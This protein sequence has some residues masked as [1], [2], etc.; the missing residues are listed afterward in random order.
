MNQNLP[1]VTIITPAYNRASFLDETI[2]SVLS[3]DYPYIEYIVLDDGSTDHTRQIL[4]K[5]NGRIVWESHINMGE[6]ATVN[7]G[8]S[9]ARGEII[10]VVNSDDPLLPGAVSHAVPLMQEN[11]DVLAVYPDWDEIDPNSELIKQIQLPE[12]N[13]LNMLTTFNVAMGPG[14]FFRR[15][16]LD[17]VGMRDPNLKYTGDLEFWFRL[18]LHGKLAHI[19]KALATHRTHPD[20]A[21][22]SDRGAIMAGELVSLVR[23]IYSHPDLPLEIRNIRAKVFCRAHHAAAKYCGSDRIAGIKHRL[24]SIW[25]DPLGYMLSYIRA[26]YYNYY[27]IYYKTFST[28]LKIIRKFLRFAWHIICLLWRGKRRRLAGMTQ[29][30]KALKFAFVSHVLPPSWS[31]QAVMIGRI[32]RGIAPDRYCLLSRQNYEIDRDQKNYSE[33]LPGEYYHLGPKLQSQGYTHSAT[34]TWA[35]TLLGVLMRGWHIARILKRERC[36]TVVA[37]TGDV[38][39]LPAACLASRLT[40]TTFYPYLF[41]DYTYQWPHPITQAIA[42]QIEAVIFQ[43]MEGIIV[44]NE[45]L[46]DEIQSRH[47]VTASIVRNPCE[48]PDAA[49][50]RNH[51]APA[52]DGAR[53]VYMGAVYHVN[54]GAFSNLITALER[55]GRPKVKL[56]LYTAQPTEFLEAEKICGEYVVVHQHLPPTQVAEVQRSAD[57]LFMPFAFDS[58][59]PE[60]VRTSAPGKFGEYLASGTPILAHVPNGSFVSWYLGKYECGLVVDRDDPSALGEALERLLDDRDLRSSLSKNAQARARADFSPVE[61]GKSFLAALDQSA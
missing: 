1:L 14:T 51:A 24:W 25:H 5:Y 31:G 50:E 11:P 53:I 23:K 15:K 58:P 46:R 16:V 9:M 42:K 29:E 28:L 52:R 45:F 12:Y 26:I 41:D 18:A 10:C 8:F 27:K 30:R 19:P 33:R 17:Q 59:V 3:Q 34:M 39:D 61:A 57:V 37:G 35:V 7:K 22:V 56:Q 55:L 54:C 60:V 6:T 13:I 36:D 44:P 2:Q 49:M 38:I 48:N 47:G 4:E 21:S 40:G 32:L 20:S 43:Q